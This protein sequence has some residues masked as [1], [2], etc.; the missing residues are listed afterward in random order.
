[1]PLALCYN[2]LM[3]SARVKSFAKLNLTL[4]VTGVKDGYHMLDSLVT[5]VDLYDAITVK[6]RRD[7]L[8]SVSMRGCGS[9]SIPFDKNNAVKAAELFIERYGVC[10]A[11]ITVYKNIPMGSGLGGSSADSAGV[12]NALSKLHKINDP[13]G[14]KLI[15]DLTGSDTR[16]MLDGGYARL[17][18][19]GNEVERLQSDLKLNFLLL[20]PDGGVSSGKCFEKFDLSGGLGGDSDGA[21]AA[22]SAG[23][24]R[25][26]CKNM[27]NALAPAAKS[28]SPDIGVAFGELLSFDPLAVNMT[29]SGSG[30]YAVFEN[31]EYC[32][33]AKSRYRGKFKT[34]CLKTVFPTE[35]IR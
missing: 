12:I 18:G 4:R 3:E 2:K 33:Y 30:V 19:R 26:L 29:G 28:L 5:T 13:V 25:A 6:K 22:L 8:V 23:D 32:A 31:A 14:M 20:V 15:A 10:G 7:K 1:M 9:E 17:Y 11:D 21:C 34:Y 24:K 16:Y 27:N 35:V